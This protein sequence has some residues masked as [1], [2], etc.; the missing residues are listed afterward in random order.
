M[1][2]LPLSVHQHFIQ[3][4]VAGPHRALD[5]GVRR[6]QDV[7]QLLRHIILVNPGEQR[8]AVHHLHV[9][10]LIAQALSSRQQRPELVLLSEGHCVEQAVR[11]LLIIQAVYLPPQRV[12]AGSVTES[13]QL[14]RVRY[15][16]VRDKLPDAAQLLTATDSGLDEVR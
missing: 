2:Q 3:L 16:G 9:R 6:I 14:P 8:E 15:Q 4:V 13:D 7:R 5:W 12:L 11:V 10:G 1:T